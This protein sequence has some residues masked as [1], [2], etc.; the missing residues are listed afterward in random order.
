[1]HFDKLK[2][3][4]HLMLKRI[5]VHVESKRKDVLTVPFHYRLVLGNE[6]LTYAEAKICWS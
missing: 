1:V 5:K 6:F 3:V 2:D 4:I